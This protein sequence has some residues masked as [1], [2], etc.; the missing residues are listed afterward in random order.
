MFAFLTPSSQVHTP[1]IGLT[2]TSDSLSDKSRYEY[3]LRVSPADRHQAEVMLDFL[4]AYNWTYFALIFSEG[5]YGENGAKI[6]AKYAKERQLCIAFSEMIYNDYTDSHIKWISKKLM[7]DGQIRAV[8]VFGFPSHLNALF[9]VLGHDQVGHFVWLG[10]D[11]IYYGTYPPMMDGGFVINVDHGKSADYEIYREHVT[12]HNYPD[13]PLLLQLWEQLHQCS[14]SPPTVHNAT[15][16]CGLY[17]NLTWPQ[18]SQDLMV[19]DAIT[20]MSMG[21]HALFE[22]N[23]QEVFENKS[24]ISSCFTGVEYLRFLRNVSFQGTTGSIRFDEAGDNVARY[25]LYQYSSSQGGFDR[26]VGEWSEYNG[27]AI[28]QDVVNWT[29]FTVYPMEARGIPDS[30]C[31]Y[32]CPARHLYI[33]QEL[34]CC[35][36]CQKCRDNEIIINGTSC[37]ACE[38]NRWPDVDTATMC[39]SIPATFIAYSHTTGYIL[40]I[41]N[42]LGVTLA[43]LLTAVFIYFRKKKIIKASSRELMSIILLGAFLAYSTVY[44][45]LCEPATTACI[46][47]QLGFILSVTTMYSPLLVKTSRVYR[48]FRAGTRGHTTLPFISSRAQIAMTLLLLILQVR[49]W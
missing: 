26:R 12:P 3:F 22:A 28:K 27:L 7:D 13:D 43:A 45:I 33:Y 40:A 48:I 14:W 24:L 9:D 8:V 35:W 2:C 5:S 31:S 47:S 19:I 1:L 17:E 44:C 23:C 11:G 4:Q 46:L 10:S 34:H 6:V 21:I 25:L 36:L 30:V 42:T 18:G 39:E 16:P 15:T 37:S 49:H 20:T 38:R 41:T 32:P 29:S